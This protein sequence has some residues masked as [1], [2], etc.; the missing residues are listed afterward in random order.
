M[1]VCV[2]ITEGLSVCECMQAIKYCICMYSSHTLGYRYFHFHFA[3]LGRAE[4]HRGPTVCLEPTVHSSL[5]QWTLYCIQHHI[6]ITEPA[7]KVHMS[8]C[9]KVWE[10]RLQVMHIS[11]WF[12]VSH[13]EVFVEISEAFLR[14]T[15]GPLNPTFL[16]FWVTSF[17]PF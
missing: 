16:V 13:I 1:Y 17:W 7:P 11:V 9:E 8:V 3:G 10:R 5:S 6:W 4:Q 12:T 2:H 14:R 15:L